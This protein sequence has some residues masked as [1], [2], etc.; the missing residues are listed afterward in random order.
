MT[1]QAKRKRDELAYRF[2]ETV[3]PGEDAHLI[4][5]KLGFDS[6]HKV[7]KAEAQVLVEALK[8][9]ERHLLVLDRTVGVSAQTLDDVQQAIK[10]YEGGGE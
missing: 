7:S 1:E 5:F 3:K 2:Y 9:A 8:E 6:G 4:A 10:K